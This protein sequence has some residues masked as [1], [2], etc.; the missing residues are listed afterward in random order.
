[1][2]NK[3]SFYQLPANVFNLK[4]VSSIKKSSPYQLSAYVFIGLFATF[5]AFLVL[6]ANFIV[7]ESVFD[8]VIT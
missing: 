8:F 5:P 2:F 3:S 6:Y 1:M 7:N 4:K